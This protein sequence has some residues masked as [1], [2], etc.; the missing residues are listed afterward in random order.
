MDT[1]EFRLTYF[2]YGADGYSSSA[3]DIFINDENLLPRIHEFEHSV[4]CNG[5]HAP[6]WIKEF[7]ENLSE[8]YKKNSIPIYGCVCGVT[9][10]C[11]IYITVEVSDKTVT[12]KNFILPDEYL[13]NKI[14]Y[15]RRFG[16]FFFDKAQ[17]FREV[18]KLNRLFKAEE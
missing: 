15:Q 10:C 16:E 1:I 6:I 8:G 3:V 14:I 2:E 17:Y 9:D 4:G 12:W 7:Y 11:A 18:E 13:F 5:G